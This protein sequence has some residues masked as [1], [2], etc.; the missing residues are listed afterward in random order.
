MMFFLTNFSTANSAQI[1]VP[2]VS[3]P[4]SKYHVAIIMGTTV[5]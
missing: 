5:E 2:K 1:L 4:F 3:G